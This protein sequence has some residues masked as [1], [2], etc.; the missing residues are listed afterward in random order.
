MHPPPVRRRLLLGQGL[1]LG[2]GLVL[3]RAPRAQGIE[4]AVLQAARR[5]G[6]LQ[7]EFDVRIQLSRTVEDALWRGVPVYF[8]ARADL[9]RGRWYWRDER[10][11]RVART[12]RVAFQPLTSS[13]RV[14]LVGGLQ[15]TFGTL[16][17][18][19]LTIS[20]ASQWKLADVSQIDPDSRHY[21]EFSFRLDETQ[22]P[23][24]MQIG[25][26][27]RGEWTLAVER[28]LALD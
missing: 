28:T 12:W 18:A 15:Q 14:G 11:A 2:L 17:E 23:G 3:A 26:G 27:G 20:R 8:V 6:E 19:L 13:W 7:L 25:L 1:V 16:S 21:V 22:L 4:L 24:P 9:Y 5:D 10:I